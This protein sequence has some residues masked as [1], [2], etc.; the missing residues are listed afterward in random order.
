MVQEESEASMTQM[1]D[2]IL[3][4]GDYFV[5][6]EFDRPVPA[7]SLHHALS[8]M[9]WGSVVFDQ[10]VRQGAVIGAM[11]KAASSATSSAKAAA[12]TSTSRIAPTATFVATPSP[13]AFRATS[14]A[15]LQMVPGRAPAPASPAAPPQ[16]KLPSGRA[17]ASTTTFQQAAPQTPAVRAALQV[18]P[19]RV[20]VKPAAES[21]PAGGGG[22]YAG[23]TFIPKNPPQESGPSESEQVSPEMIVEDPVPGGGGGGGGGSS[24]EESAMP[25]E[26]SLDPVEAVKRV[27]I[28]LWRRWKEWGSPFAGPQGPGQATSVSGNV[29]PGKTRA[30]FVG[31]L[32]R[33]ISINDAAGMRWL[34]VKRLGVPTF[35]DLTLQYTPFVLKTGSVYE[36][37]MLSR[38]RSAATREQVRE[39]LATMGFQPMKL[40][41]LKLNMR[42]PGRPGASLTLWYGIG[43]WARADS[44][45]VNDDP[46][47]FENVKEV[48]T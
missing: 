48:T 2:V 24:T 34:F 19:N 38:T 37:R 46:F 7:A 31:R 18:N 40:L 47:F 36:F 42:L 17:I 20:P 26:A 22:K 35:S 39:G 10:S 23:A 4:P 6:M 33:P 9:G 12:P 43:Q 44:M 21:K 45:V 14:S 27:L 25:A 13:A 5:E 3:H 8:A 15:A 11:A 28:D 29:D 1:R 32:E 30:R 16:V 41:A